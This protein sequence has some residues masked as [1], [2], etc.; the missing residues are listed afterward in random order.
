V[1][2]YV[3]RMPRRYEADQL[4]G[5]AEIAQRMGCAKNVVHNWERRDRTFPRPIAR[6]VMGKL[7]HWPEVEAWGRRTG[8]IV[9]VS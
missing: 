6:L 7:W 1:V 3:C 4:V 2:A 9:E 5:A 8:R